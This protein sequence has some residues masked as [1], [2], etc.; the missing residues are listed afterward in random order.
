M[1][2]PHA[3]QPIVIVGAGIAGLSCARALVEAGRQVVVIERARGVGGRCATRRYEEQPVDFGVVF[4]HGRD[5][6]FLAALDATPATPLPGWPTEIHGAGRPC[7][8]EAFARDERRLAFAEGVSA[9]PKHLARGLDVRTFAKVT[10]VAI[11]GAELCLDIEGAAPLRAR[12]VILAL[13]SEQASR[14]LETMRDAPRELASARALLAMIRPQPCLTVIAGYPLDVPAP[15]WH[16]SYPEDSRVL[17][18][19]AHDSSKRA[20]KSFVAMVI[21]AHA[22][23]SREHLA[24]PDFPRA[25]LA[26]VARLLGPWAEAPRFTEPHRWRYART[27][28]GAELS[29]PLLLRLPGGSRLGLA[30][31]IFAPG[32]GVEAAWVAGQNLARRIAAEEDA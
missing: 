12:T 2:Q 13:A 25:L 21:Q 24:D 8:P 17:Q 1:A 16:V 27:D 19:I 5:P 3:Q 32:G 28:L 18:L 9:F 14:L 15:T 4:Y 31:E 22:R 30:G 20:R 23:W 29:G 10:R 6:G 11:D 7:Q 26:E